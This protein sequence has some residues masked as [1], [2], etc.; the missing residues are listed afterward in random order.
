MK[1]IATVAAV[2]AM[3]TLTAC[4]R[5]GIGGGSAGTNS[6]GNTATASTSNSSAGNSSASA[7]GPKPA[8]GTGVQTPTGATQAGSGNVTLDRAFMMG[9]WTDNGDCN[10]SVNFAS[11]GSFTTANGTG[12]LWRL[13]GDQLTMTGSSTLTLQVEPVDQNTMTVIN[14]DGSLGRST[15]C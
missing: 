15:R 13:A 8:D 2:A 14:A 11:D 3:L 12:G 5:L 4:D 9:R 6:S 7:D 1:R 10:N